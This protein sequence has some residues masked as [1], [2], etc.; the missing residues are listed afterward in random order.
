MGEVPASQT[1]LDIGQ[2]S[3]GFDRIY[4]P[5]ALPPFH[6]RRTRV[7]GWSR[8]VARASSAPAEVVPGLLAS[9]LR[10]AG[11]AAAA[12][13]GLGLPSLIAAGL[14]GRL[15]RT[16]N[17]ARGLDVR[18]S[19]LRE[20][21]RLVAGLRGADLLIAI[22]R[23][24][25]SPQ[26]ALTIGIAGRGFGGDLTSDSTRMDGYVLT[27]DIAPTILVRLGLGVPAQ[28]SGQPIH[29]Q[30]PLDPSAVASLGKRLAAISSRRGPVLGA[31]VAIWL[32][33]LLLVIAATRGR[34]AR[35]G[36]RLAGLAVVYLPLVLLAGAALRP[37]QG[38]EGLL[39]ILGAPLLGVLTLAGL[40]GGYRALAFASALTVSAY[41][42]DVIA[43]SPLTPLSLLGPNPGLGVRFYGIGNE[44]EA[45]LAVLII[46]GT[47]AAFAGFWPGIPGRRAA[48][49]FLAIGALL[50]FVFSAGA[51]GADIGAAITLPV[52]AAGAAVAI[53]SPRRRRAGAVL[54]VLI[55]PFVALGLV[56]LVDLVSG[57][58]SHFA[59]SVLDTNSL[60]Q[61]A[62]VAR[63]RLQAA[64]GSFVRPLLLAFMPLV[65]AVCAIAI[66]HRNRLADWL[67]GLPAMRAGLLGAL[68]ATVV[69]SVAN[70]SGLLF[71]EVG[72]AYLLVF[73]GYVW[74]EAGHSAVPAAR[75]SEP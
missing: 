75:S 26:G 57:S 17:P 4:D 48:L 38:A 68:A 29:S 72:A 14:D 2:G 16:A 41:V 15:R 42:V 11:L 37:S 25:P 54:L 59:R 65:L 23:P 19:S 43:G 18:R 5:T 3:R 69:G 66:L 74:A 60:E 51:F 31:G 56:A 20:L 67:H 63:R 47:G 52:G 45:L 32:A 27:T 12:A 62:R 13:P 30:G 58:N 71:A 34:A 40:G 8:V 39:V 46:A 55:C 36:V 9:A 22:E 50:A 28:M 7:A 35:S 49:V 64:A 10:R 33:A 1:Y 21:R 61:L 53:T 70:D 6:V 24:P 73:T 44:L